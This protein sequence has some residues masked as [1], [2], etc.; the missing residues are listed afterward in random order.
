MPGDHYL[1][2]RFS[3]TPDEP[4]PPGIPLADERDVVFLYR[5]HP[6]KKTF[7][8]SEREM[9]RMHQAEPPV[10]IHTEKI[11]GGEIVE[12]LRPVAREIDA[13]AIVVEKAQCLGVAPK[14]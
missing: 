2:T 1:D 8:T 14:L 4:F 10:L 3:Q 5:L 6:A 9:Y 12:K 11:G 13:P 7:I